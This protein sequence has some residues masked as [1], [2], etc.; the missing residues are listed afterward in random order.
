MFFN[1]CTTSSHLLVSVP[2]GWGRGGEQ[3]D[4]KCGGVASSQMPSRD[5]VASV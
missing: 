2:P 1:K 4:A 3:A 5:R